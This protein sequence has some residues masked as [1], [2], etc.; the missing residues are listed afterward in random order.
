MITDF[1]LWY[2]DS[3]NYLKLNSLLILKDLSVLQYKDMLSLEVKSSMF[4]ESEIAL[5]NYSVCCRQVGEI[6]EP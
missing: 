4:F 5:L 2:V 1:R 6:I 3:F